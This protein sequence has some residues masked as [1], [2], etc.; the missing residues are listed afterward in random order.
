MQYSALENYHLPNVPNVN[1][2]L[3]PPKIL[4]PDPA[5]LAAI[6]G[7]PPGAWINRAPTGR[8]SLVVIIGAGTGGIA[9]DREGVRGGDRMQTT[10]P[11]FLAA[12]DIWRRR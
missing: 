3:I 5:N 11:R 10:N 6:A 12:G 9:G 2:M 8:C 7:L 1:A 4:P